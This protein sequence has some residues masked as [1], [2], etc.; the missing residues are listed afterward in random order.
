[1][2]NAIKDLGFAYSTISGLSTG[3]DDYV[4][5]ETK[6]KLLAAAEEKAA[7][8]SEQYE[9][10]LST[11]SE[12]AR[13]T[14]DV[15]RKVNE[16]IQ[17]DLKASFEGSDNSTTITVV[18]GARAKLAAVSQ[19]SGMLGLVQDVYGNTIELPI[20][21]NYKEGLSPV[22]YFSAARGSRKG[23]IDTALKTADSGYLTRRMV[24]VSQDVFTIEEDC[25]DKEGRII[26]SAESK[27]IGEKLVDRLIGRFAAS[28][29]KDNKGA[30]IAKRNELLTA[31]HIR[32]IEEAGLKEAHVRSALQCKSLRGI[33]R[34]CY[35]VDLARGKLVDMRVP[36]GV[37]AAQAVGEPGT[38]LTLRTF[39]KGGVAEADITHGLPRVEELFEARNP[40]GQA[41]ISEIAGTAS[42]N[43]D[44]DD[45]NI[46]VTSEGA[47][48]TSHPLGGQEPIVKPAQKVKKGE[49]LAEASGKGKDLES[50]VDGLVYFGEGS[51]DVVEDGGLLWQ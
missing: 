47:K 36:V 28:T 32:Q 19:I 11:D 51:L 49:V 3:M 16:Q 26:T 35:G 14:I 22:E 24:D 37:I 42:V 18:S 7:K 31:E 27:E 5:P 29:I 50:K 45:Y 46:R 17:K 2:G 4:I 25:G 20:K 41:I 23:L 1:V 34:T 30:I 8:I 6:K 39:H 9:H 44:G 10:G 13:Q 21:S 40:K 15:W 48:V 12:R 33:C 38:Q 43:Q